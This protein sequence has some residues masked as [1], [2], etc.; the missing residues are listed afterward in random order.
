MFKF[1][2]RKKIYSSLVYILPKTWKRAFSRH[3]RAV[4]AKK[5]TKM[6]DARA[7]LLFCP[8]NLLLFWRSRCRRCHGILK[9]VIRHETWNYLPMIKS[10]LCVKQN[11]LPSIS[12][13]TLQTSKMNFENLLGEHVFKNN[14][15]V[16]LVFFNFA[17]PCF[18]LYWLRW[19]Y[20]RR[21]FWAVILLFHVAGE[22]SRHFATPPLVSPRNDVWEMNAEIPYWWRVTTQIWEVFLIGRAAGEI[23]FNQS[24][25]LP[26]SR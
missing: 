25:A 9:S 8:F 26:I 24:K 4:T 16:L 20:L 5:C 18:L 6:R 2:K 17:Y 11:C 21:M 15:C 7:D 14:N 23:C 10:Q 19:L 3:S 12:Y 1:R 22:K 13:Q